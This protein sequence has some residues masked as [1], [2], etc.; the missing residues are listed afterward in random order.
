MLSHTV[1]FTLKDSSD[2][3]CQ[4]LVD[5]AHKFLKPHDGIAYFGIG[6][7]AA[8]YDRPVNDREFHIALNV[9]F[10]TKEAHDVYQVSEKHLEFIALGKE[11]WDKVRVFD[12]YV[13]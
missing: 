7:L 5:A 11:N 9:V 1:F 4:F 13:D 12:A 2:A 6:K 3:A 10:D 8:E